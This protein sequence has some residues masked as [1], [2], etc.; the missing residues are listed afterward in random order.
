MLGSPTIY[1][2]KLEIQKANDVVQ[3]PES[4]RTFQIVSE[5]LRT[6]TAKVRKRFTFQLK[7]SGRGKANPTFST[8]SK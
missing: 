2:L 8:F 4:Q 6:R 5:S 7:Q 3:R 1:H